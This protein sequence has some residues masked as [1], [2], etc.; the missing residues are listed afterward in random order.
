M[1]RIVLGALLAVAACGGS[2]AGAPTPPSNLTV[3]ESAG[4]AHLTWTDNSTNEA[5][6]IVERKTGTG[7]FAQLAT[8]PF[9]TALYHDAAVTSGT[10]YVYR[11]VAMGEGGHSAH[12]APTNEVP[13]TAP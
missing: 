13:F 1:H 3:V 9:N 12:S 2:G 8:V 7:N 11:V 6:F 10:M 4:G 5:Q